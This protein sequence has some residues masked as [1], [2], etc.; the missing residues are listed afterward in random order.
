[1]KPSSSD[2]G[3]SA[4]GAGLTWG[5]SVA[6]LTLVGYWGDGQLD[7][8]PLFVVLGAV[9]GSVGGF[10]HFLSRVAPEVLPFGRQGK[11]GTTDDASDSDAP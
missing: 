3:G 9:F 2:R 1:M 4:L 6:V 11:A 10:I 7:T 5:V 8:S